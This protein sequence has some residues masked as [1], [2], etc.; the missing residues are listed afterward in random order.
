MQK[1]LKIGMALGLVLAGAVLLWLATR[2][3]LSVRSRML[4]SN[5]V[6]SSE[7][8][9]IEPEQ[10]NIADLT[11]HRQPEKTRE[12]RFHT[13]VKGQSLS[14]ISR[15]FYGTENKWRKILGANRNVIKD[16]DKLKPGTKLIIP[17]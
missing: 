9:A 6:L 15:L 12:Q 2:Q 5:K 17:D 4:R 1:D 14:E 13:V 7:Q 8:A 10:N 11:P 16:A 3:S